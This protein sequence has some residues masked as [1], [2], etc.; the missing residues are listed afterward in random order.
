MSYQIEQTEE[1]AAW[2]RA[3]RDM[4]AR[5]AIYRR[6]DRAAAGLLGDVKPVGEGVS[7]M[8]VDVGAGYRMY[9]TIRDQ[10]VIFLL[11]G[12]DK[13]SQDADI[14]HARKLAKEV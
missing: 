8:R 10:T 6:I 13:S 12:G 3:L 4:R 7:E 11:H 9:F 5:A 1:F 2:H 14:R